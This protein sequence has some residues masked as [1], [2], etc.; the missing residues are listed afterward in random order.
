MLRSKLQEKDKAMLAAIAELRITT[1][2]QL[3][4]KQETSLQMV[5][6]R[7]RRLLNNKLVI[8]TPRGLGCRRGRPEDIYSVTG[9]GFDELTNSQ[10]LSPE[11][12]VDRVTGGNLE[13]MIGHQLLLNSVA[14]QCEQLSEARQDLDITFISST[15]PSHVGKSGGSLVSQKLIPPNGDPILFIPDAACSIDNEQMRKRLL[16]FVEVDMGT[17]PKARLKEEQGED[18]RRKILI[19]RAFLG[20]RQYEGVQRLFGGTFHGFRLLLLAHTPARR[21]ALCRA[22]R[23]MKQADFIW[24]SDQ[25]LMGEHGIGGTI[26]FRG[27]NDGADR[28]SIL[29][30][31]DV[32]A[33]R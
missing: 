6:R 2:S 14:I 33:V 3:S 25:S 11:I 21:Q 17:E 29:G 15:S 13:K 20:S 32:L 9:K 28:E 18:I 4:T 23:E 27:G 7:C 5:R 8:A 26:W 10:V 24:I 31:R 16:F 22:V 1:V 12:P 30:A 19:Y